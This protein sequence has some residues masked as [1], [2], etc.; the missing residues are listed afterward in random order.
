LLILLNKI[1]NN[2]FLQDTSFEIPADQLDKYEMLLQFYQQIFT[3]LPE[4]G[5]NLR[6]EYEAEITNTRGPNA[7]NKLKKQGILEFEPRELL[8]SMTKHEMK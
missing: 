3:D 5:D 8:L 4:L 1:R 6:T 7:P 2:E